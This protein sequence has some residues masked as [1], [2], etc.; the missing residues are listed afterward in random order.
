MKQRILSSVV[1]V[2][3]FATIVIFNESFPVSLNIAISIISVICV[4]ELVKASDLMRHWALHIPSLIVAAILPFSGI[5][6]QGVF[7]V[8]S[9]YS[10]VM[11]IALIV[12]HR[13]ITFKELAIIYSMSV[14]I[15]SAL[16]TIV[17]TRALS[18][19][20]GMFYAMVAVLAAW[21]PDVGAYL[22]GTFFGKHKLCPDISPKK[23]VEGLVGGMIFSMA[24]MVLIGMFFS[25]IYY[26]G[27]KE[28]NY[29]ALMLVGLGGALTS[30]VGD[31][32]F[33]LIKRSCGV[34]DFGQ[35]IPGHGGVLDRFD[36]V[37]FTAPY[38]Y[39]LVTY[40]PMVIS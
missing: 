4:H 35:L 2:A 38:V 6:Y 40:M 3:F 10:L 37:I 23:T 18:E 5:I 31:L 16:L 28:A 39:L 30:T 19:H 7:I 34:K 36:S 33:S 21:V 22:S 1:L 15:P 12:Y 11:F 17:S 8:Y 26:D 9:I 25:F 32:S 20:H 13:T 24:F 29:I 14:M 27:Q